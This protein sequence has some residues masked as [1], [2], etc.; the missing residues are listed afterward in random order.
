MIKNLLLILCVTIVST[1]FSFSQITCNE[2][3]L[4]A[5]C[6][7][8]DIDGVIFTNPD[9]ANSTVPSD[10]LCTDG[11]QFHN[12]GWFSFVAGST[13]IE[14]LVTPQPGTCDTIP[15]PPNNLTG[16]QV[17]L[18]EGCPDN[19]GICVGGDANCNDT[20]VTLFAD[21][22]VIG[23]IYNLT[24]DGCGGSVCTVE[25]DITS[26]SQFSLPD[27][28]DVDM[29]EAEYNI[30][31]NC[32]NALGEGNFCAGIPVNFSVDD[33]FYESLGA[34]WE[35]SFTGPDAGNVEWSFGAFSGTGSPATIGDVDGEMLEGN[36]INAIFPGPG[37][38]T[39]CLNNVETFCDRDA[40]GKLTWEINIIEPGIQ[41]FGTVS[42][43][44]LDLLAGWEPDF[45]DENGNPW[46]AGTISLDDVESA[47][48]GIVNIMTADECGC[49][50]EQQIQIIVAG[51]ID[52]EE[53]E[54][55]VWECMF[56][57]TWYD[58]TF[59]EFNDLPVGQSETLFEGSAE[60]DFEGNV[61][62]SLVSITITPLEIIDTVI[63]GNCT[64]MGTEFTFVFTALDPEGND[65]TIT[66][67]SIEWIDAT[68]NSIVAT[69]ATALLQSG[70]Y[71]V[72]FLG[73]L[74]DLNFR[75]DELAGIELDSECSILLGPFDL[76]GGSSTTPAIEPYQ[77]IYCDADLSLLTFTIDTLPDTDYTWIIPPSYNVLFE[78]EDS[79]AVS[80]TTFVETDTLFAQASNG[81]GTSDSIPLPITITSGPD[82]ATNG[83]PT[84]CSG[85]EFL[86]GYSGSATNIDTYLWD[87]GGGII[88]TGDATSQNIGITYDTPGTFTYS[89]LVTDTEGCTSIESFTVDVQTPLENPI[90]TCSGD[91]SSIVFTWVD[92]PGAISY[93]IIDIDLPPGAM[94]NLS[95][96]TYT[97]TGVSPNDQATI[98]VVSVGATSCVAIATNTTCSASSCDI[99]GVQIVSFDDIVICA[100]D[101]NNMPV[102][103]DITL[104][105]NFSGL[106]TGRGVDPFS[107]LFD[108][109]STEIE[110]GVFEIV[111]D[112]TDGAACSG[113]FIVDLIVNEIPAAEIMPSQATFCVGETI[114]LSGVGT[115][116]TWDFGVDFVGD[117]T[118][119]SYT[120]PGT[121][122]VSV[123]VEDPTSLCMSEDMIELTVNDVVEDPVI[124][125]MPGTDNVQ[126]D[127][128]DIVGVS[129]YEISISVAGGMPVITTQTNSDFTQDGLNEGDIVEIIITAAADNGCNTPVVSETCQA[130][131]CQIPVIELSASQQIFCSNDI[132]SNP[133]N[134]VIRVDGASP[135]DGTFTIEGDGVALTGTNA[136]FDPMDLAAGMYT[137]IFTFTNPVDMCQ[138]VETIDFELIDVPVPSFVLDN[139]EICIDESVL[140]VFPTQPAN[141]SDRIINFLPAQ[142]TFINPDELSLEYDM[143]GVFDLDLSYEID[144]C[145]DPM[146]SEQITVNDTIQTPNIVCV[147]VDTDFVEFGWQDQTLVSEYEIFIDGTFDSTISDSG[148][149]LTG[150]TAG[151]SRT[152]RVIAI[153]PICGNKEAEF[154]CTAQTCVEPTWVSN[155]PT[156]QCYTPGSGPI[157]LD[158]D[159]MSLNPNSTGIL[160][161]L[162]PEVNSNNEFTPSDVSQEYNFTALF[163]EGNCTSQFPI[164]FRINVEPTA[165]LE[166]IGDNVICVGSSVSV[167]S[168]FTPVG[169]E[170]AVWNF[171]GAAESGSDFGPYTVTFDETR[172]YRIEVFIDN[173]GCLGPIEFIEI[174]VEPEL[175]A[176]IVTCNSNDINS[177]DLTWD[178][179]ICADEYIVFVDGS[180]V[181]TTSNLNFTVTGL[182]ENQEIS[183]IVEAISVCACSNSVSQEVQCNSRPC[184]PT[185]FTFSDNISGD[186]CLDGTV[187]PFI[188][189]ATPDNLAGTGTGIWSGTPISNGM[190]GEVDPTLVTPGTFD[191]EYN[192]E[193]GG[194]TYA[195]SVQLTFVP[196]PTLELTAM[197]PAC[198]TDI[199]GSISAL[200][201]GGSP[202]YMFSIDGG[203]LQTSGD[204]DNLDIGSHTVEIVDANGCLN[205][206]SISI[207]APDAP[208]VFVEG[209]TTVIV[210]NDAMFTLDIQNADNIENIVW[211]MNGMEVCNGASCLTYS[212][213]NASADFT[214]DVDVIYDGGCI[215]SAEQFFV[216]VREVQAFYI[217]NTV[218]LNAIDGNNEWN[219]FI[220][221]NET[222]PRSILIYDRWGNLIF[223]NEFAL[224]NP[225]RQLLLW[226]GTSDN[227][228]IASGVYVYV[229]EIEI[230]GRT[231]IIGGDITIL[232]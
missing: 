231:E 88:T 67:P 168:M 11:G 165:N 83:A 30:R 167:E 131:T 166:L 29:A 197:D 115:V 230:E 151:D 214:I 98:Q 72:E 125:C 174:T 176:P 159:A 196:E 94:T 74:Q 62:D 212:V 178:A 139:S 123:M 204:F 112:F 188:I 75:D 2:A 35:W 217:P 232:R 221:G 229:L 218:A 110:V 140:A 134:I 19:G 25:V 216:D 210:E 15:N 148:L 119:L 91:P 99:S 143:P 113:Q 101:P 149:T 185:T 41:D 136:T 64:S 48:D 111:F 42:V 37:M 227:K 122:M 175:E 138:T 132:V 156:V 206:A 27:L 80:I 86:V 32:E 162:E 82:L 124:I 52:R 68:D 3:E 20:P 5:L 103:F 226:D 173:E 39:V 157:I 208:S 179:V 50:F 153:D 97:I 194:C 23:D 76:I 14:L 31:G 40:E 34:Q 43:C 8:G 4:E 170:V 87:A 73:S 18:W 58:I 33:D 193:E 60:S 137:A 65:I 79:L 177:V 141:V 199:M 133:V 135:A 209:P 36:G 164:T 121:K 220:K 158:V 96:N 66:N 152:I 161:W 51:S 200:G 57:Y 102:Q 93:D 203:A 128:Q 142:G 126:F 147:N 7:I 81:C 24:I 181:T 70:S 26:A 118:G 192:Y 211:T 28:N 89:L 219:I 213:I 90:V 85:S 109:N 127:W 186:V 13:S 108:P 47:T 12:P 224:T 100:G 129:S 116:A 22:L 145:P 205:S 55:F 45:E 107:G 56:P 71:F 53:V 191:V 117:E 155:V 84:N 17:A 198:A 202:G 228:D 146:F 183:V 114:T 154:T 207:L 215:V 130:R 21:N 77:E 184:E 106:Y 16:V 180:E 49:D 44:A 171:D 69:G 78:A 160:S 150:L 38:Y 190:T 46:I 54:L 222:F 105:A 172:T 61:C 59:D 10:A 163:T 189:S 120:T 95:G 92:V 169:N 195:T 225:E 6:D 187:Q 1:T 182:E 104:P 223:E 63:V 9:P 201:M 144:N